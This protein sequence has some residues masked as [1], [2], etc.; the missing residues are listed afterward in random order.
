MNRVKLFLEGL[1]IGLG[2]IIPGVSGALFA[3]LFGQYEIIVECISNPRMLK[4][5]FHS[6]FP[7][8]LGVLF[9]ILGGSNL[10]GFLLANHYIASLSF[11]IGMM[12]YGTVPFAK[13]IF[14]SK[15]SFKEIVLSLLSVVII[16]LLLF[17]KP[18]V[19]RVRE[20]TGLFEFISL[21]LCGFLDAGSTIIPGISGTALLMLLGV[22]EKI[23]T[24]LSLLSSLQFE[25]KIFEILLPFTLGL[26][27]GLFLF[28][29]I[30]DYLFKNCANIM[31]LS[32]FGF[33][34]FSIVYLSLGLFSFSQTIDS[35]EVIF[36]ATLGYISSYLLEEKMG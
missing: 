1:V 17:S 35:G 32:I 7:I 29:K 25:P 20:T 36:L 5:H 11:F 16:A 34:V 10:I 14:C 27:I 9:A 22:Y 3:M 15:I 6:I 19:S 13:K 30:A 31:N 8:G 4:E 26:G 18:E 33:T 12:I 28:A 2:K 23:I 24:C 21:F